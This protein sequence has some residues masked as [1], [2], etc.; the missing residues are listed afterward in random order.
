MSEGAEIGPEQLRVIARAA[1]LD[2]PPDRLRTL[3]RTWSTFQR[4]FEPLWQ[5]NLGDREPTPWLVDPVD[6][7]P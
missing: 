7:A 4:D 6:E 3:L 2:V 1:G 5:L